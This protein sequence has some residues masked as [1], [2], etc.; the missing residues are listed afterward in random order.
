MAETDNRHFSADMEVL[1][2]YVLDQLDPSKRRHVED[3]LR[4]CE[5]CRRAVDQER[6]LAAGVRRYGR[7]ELRR[8]L[9]GRRESAVARRIRWQQVLAA[10][11]VLV[12]LAGVS[13]YEKWFIGTESDRVQP[14]RELSLRVEPG[15][16]RDEDRA[17]TRTQED[18][19]MAPREAARPSP[20]PSG[21]VPASRSESATGRREEVLLDKQEQ[22]VPLALS[23]NDADRLKSKDAP[24]AYHASTVDREE[25]PAPVWAEGMILPLYTTAQPSG[26]RTSGLAQKKIAAAG[27]EREGQSPAAEEKPAGARFTVSQQ[28]SSALPRSRLVMQR[29]LQAGTI[30]TLIDRRADSVHLTLFLDSLIDHRDLE[31]VTVRTVTPD[32]LIVNIANQRIGYRL[33]AGWQRHSPALRK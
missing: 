5:Q 26:A 16:H 14:S 4:T 15:S 11:A 30:Q 8:R 22:A 28:L 10:A 23:V 20:G 18:K 21:T 13:V 24:Y 7:N 1:E 17:K 25:A 32:S 6:L 27:K 12:V 29:N 19:A 31:N 3:H 33:P 9:A 2:E